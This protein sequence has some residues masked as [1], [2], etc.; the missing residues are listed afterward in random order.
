MIDDRLGIGVRRIL[1]II[2][3]LAAVIVSTQV[4]ASAAGGAATL[5]W[6]RN[7]AGQAGD[8]TWVNRS[9]PARTCAIGSTDCA[10]NPLTGVKAL[11]GGNSSSYALLSSGTV[12]AWGSNDRGALGD[13]TTTNRYAPVL[14][15][16]VGATDCPANPLAGVRAIAAGEG[17]A[18]A[19]LTNGTVVSWGSN[20]YGQLGDGASEHRSTPALVC[21]VGA[22]DC[23]TNPL[24]NVRA[25]GAGSLHSLAVLSDGSIVSWGYNSSG[26]LGDGSDAWVR[27]T[28]VPV[29]VTG[30]VAVAAGAAFSLALRADGTVLS[31][32]WNGSGQLGDNTTTAR[33]LPGPV[34]ATGATDCVASPL[35]GIKSIAAGH[36]GAHSIALRADGRPLVW[37][38]NGNGELGDGSDL[39][40][41]TPV[42]VCAVHATDCSTQTLTDI[43]ALAAGNQFTIARTAQGTMLAWGA[44]YDGQLGDGTN[45]LTRFAPEHVLSPEGTG[46][47]TGVTSISAGYWHSLAVRTNT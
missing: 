25:I 33:R 11:A 28:P 46:P 36:S 29:A 10:A 45:T 31:W 24:T 27:R 14:V 12:A 43:T 3:V 38:F 2:V 13:G 20:S 6:G 30:V 5:G 9:L 47:L 22:T 35:S 4:P 8:N 34:C 19:L 41:S 21:A 7:L 16:A 44:G 37:G 15:C 40:R 39:S 23:A 17:H 1:G 42:P 32:G 18:L 26:Q